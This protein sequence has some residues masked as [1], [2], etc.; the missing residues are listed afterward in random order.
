MLKKD[1]FH[2][3]FQ[4]DFGIGG[5]LFRNQQQ[6]ALELLKHSRSFF[7]TQS[8]GEDF[9][10]HLNRVK[11]LLSQLFSDGSRRT[12]NDTFSQSLLHVIAQKDLPPEKARHIVDLIIDDLKSRNEKQRLFAAVRH[13]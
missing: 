4:H 6:L 9:N 8:T 11:A 13:D 10:K 2:L 1:A 7:Y 5:P 12:V 3:L